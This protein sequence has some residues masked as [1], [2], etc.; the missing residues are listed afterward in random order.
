MYRYLYRRRT[1]TRQTVRQTD[2]QTD[3]YRLSAVSIADVAPEG[4]AEHHPAKHHLQRRVEERNAR[5][6]GQT[7]A[8]SE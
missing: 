7:A 2:R 8:E 4:R 1:P 3:T 6:T 5:N